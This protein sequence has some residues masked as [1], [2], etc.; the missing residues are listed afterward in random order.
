MHWLLM[1]Q[2][3]IVSVYPTFQIG[4]SSNLDIS[5]SSLVVCLWVVQ[6]IETSWCIGPTGLT[7]FKRQHNYSIHDPRWVPSDLFAIVLSGICSLSPCIYVAEHV[8][9]RDTPGLMARMG[10][11]ERLTM[12]ALQ[13][14][15]VLHG[16]HIPPSY[17]KY[18]LLWS[19]IHLARGGDPWCTFLSSFSFD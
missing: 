17:P 1:C 18:R 12:I 16:G 5:R 14:W 4:A 11:E 3:E 13:A 2:M 19:M 15:E 7:V 9:A 8:A 6:A 10:N